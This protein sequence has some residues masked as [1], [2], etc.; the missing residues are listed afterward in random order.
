MAAPTKPAWFDEDTYLANKLASLQAT[1]PDGNWTAQSMAD[2]FVEAGYVDIHTTDGTDVYQ[3]FLDYGNSENISPSPYFDVDYYY[4]AKA[5][6]FFNEAFDDV[7]AMHIAKIKGAFAENNLSAW[8]HYTQYGSQEGIA[9]SANFDTQAYLEA[10]AAVLN[11]T[12]QDGETKYTAEDVANAIHDAGWNALEHYMMYKG[13]SD[14]E[15]AADATFNVG[16][17]TD[18]QGNVI[19]VEGGT[20]NL[21]TDGNDTFLA[22]GSNFSTNTT[23]DGGK[24]HDV[25]QADIDGDSNLTPEIKNVEELRFDV[26]TQ[27][28]GHLGEDNPS[29]AHIDA[30]R[31]DPVNGRLEIWSNNSRGDLKVEDV[32]VASSNTTIG[33][34]NTNP[35]GVDMS[36]YFDNQYLKADDITTTGTLRLQIIDTIGALPTSYE[37]GYNSPLYN[38]SYTGFRFILNDHTYTVDFGEYNVNTDPNPTYQELADKIDATIKADPELSQLGLSVTLGDP[39]DS[40]V[41]IGKYKDTEVTGGVEI[42]LKTDQGALVRLDKGGWIQSGDKPTTDSTSATMDVAKQDSCPLIKT[43]IALDNVGQVQWDEESPCLPDESL[44]G[45]RAGDLV[46]GAMGTRGGVERFDATVDR[47]SWLDRIDSTNQTLRYI[48]AVN[49]EGSEGQLFIGSHQGYNNLTAFEGAARLLGPGLTDVAVFDAHAMHGDVNIGA[50]ITEAANL[51]YLTDKDGGLD[52]DRGYAPKGVFSYDTGSGADTINMTVDGKVAADNAFKMNIN[53]GEGDDLVSFALTKGAGDN[54]QILGIDEDIPSRDL[55]Y[56]KDESGKLGD[57]KYDKVVIDTG[58]GDDT[59]LLPGSGKAVVKAG[60]GNDVI[61]TDNSGYYADGNSTTTNYYDR[62]WGGYVK[63]TTTT[64]TPHAVWILNSETDGSDIVNFDAEKAGQPLDN[65]ALSPDNDSHTISWESAKAEAGS[66]DISVTFMDITSTETI[67]WAAKDVTVK[68]G[69]CSYKIN[70]DDINAAIIKAVNNDD[71]LTHIL[72]AKYGAGH[73]LIL[74]SLIDGSDL[75]LSID[76]SI[77]GVKN[78]DPTTPESIFTSY[79]VGTD[80]GNPEGNSFVASYLNGAVTIVTDLDT[81]NI[82]HIA[83]PDEEKAVPTLGGE[84]GSQASNAYS[85]ADVNGGAGNDLIVLSSSENS[86]E[87]VSFDKGFGK[88]T[89][90][91][92][93]YAEK[94]DD[95][96]APAEDTPYDSLHFSGYKAGTI[97]EWSTSLKFGDAKAHV[98]VAN[99]VEK[100]TGTDGKITTTNVEDYIKGLET[101]EGGKADK[102]GSVMFLNNQVGETV[103]ATEQGT[104]AAW[105]VYTADVA[106]KDG[107]IS[108]V[109]YQGAITLIGVSGEAIDT[110]DEM[111]Q[112]A[113]A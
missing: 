10:K 55:R 15:V 76:F 3:H 38:N 51:K 101:D 113:L 103:D 47:G 26:R 57:L 66:L 75:P 69:T 64:T 12:L 110:A 70:D 52:I 58:A 93:R 97:A 17:G 11:A 1:D 21:G 78:G 111:T 24:G 94:S 44:F 6:S 92:F 4:Q 39:F 74:E 40:I 59:V 30:Q 90:L 48:Q 71:V 112:V 42:V 98:F 22:Y 62:D 33:M 63:A 56:I 60:A 65:S 108:N 67:K 50:Q 82:V 88:D 32:R 79:G 34:S 13:E 109:T 19:R 104:D 18:I 107:T 9:A 105:Y 2:A 43:D 73:S 53:T 35:G 45:S 28:N 46:V 61:F 8:D 102:D 23:I 36:V 5:A 54:V 89:I 25:L 68:D 37:G 16:G 86:A 91:N 31:I 27:T 29:Y 81:G 49:A 14:R 7:S 100:G 106:A 96:D 83:Q 84:E 87:M 80:T 20:A 99:G 41:N 77:T 95:P 72:D 85:F